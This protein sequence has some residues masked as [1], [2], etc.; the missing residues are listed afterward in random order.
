MDWCIMRFHYAG[1]FATEGDTLT[2]EG[3]LV[4]DLRVDPDRLSW[5][6]L[7]GVLRR[8]GYR[9]IKAIYY[10][11][12][13]ASLA[14]GIRIL[15]NDASVNSMV[16]EMMLEGTIDVYVEH[17]VEEPEVALH[18]IEGPP[19]NDGENGNEGDENNVG[20]AEFVDIE[21]EVEGAEQAAYHGQVAGED[22]SEVDNGDSGMDSDSVASSYRDSSDFGDLESDL[23]E[24]VDEATRRDRRYPLYNEDV[25]V[26][27]ITEGMIFMNAAQFKRADIYGVDVYMSMVRRAKKKIL[28]SYVLNIEEE[29]GQ[30]W[31]QSNVSYR[32]AMVEDENGDSWNWFLELVQADLDHMGNGAGWTIMSDQHKAIEKAIKDITPEAEHREFEENLEKLKAISPD[33]GTDIE[34]YALVQQ[35]CRAFQKEESMLELIDNNLCEALNKTLLEA[36]R[37]SALDISQ[38][39]RVFHNG[40]RGYEIEHGENRY[41]VRL[42][43]KTCSCRRY[44]LSG[45]PC[46]HAICAIRDVRVDI[47]EYTSS[48]LW[49][50]TYLKAYGKSLQ[51]VPGKKVWPITND[52]P[53]RPPEFRQKP[54]KPQLARKKGPNEPKKTKGPKKA[55]GGVSRKGMIMTCTH[56]HKQNHNKR[57]CPYKGREIPTATDQEM[58][59]STQ[60]G[61]QHS[62]LNTST[63][64]ASTSNQATSNQAT[65]TQAASNQA[66]SNWKKRARASATSVGNASAS[67]SITAAGINAT[68]NANTR[69]QSGPATAAAQCSTVFSAPST[70]TGTAPGNTP[71]TNTV[72]ASSKSK[73]KRKKG[74]NTRQVSGRRGVGFS[75]VGGAGNVKTTGGGRSSPQSRAKAVGK[76][77]IT[78]S[79]LQKEAQ[80]K[81]KK[82]FGRSGSYTN[83]FTE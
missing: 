76:K 1:Y 10:R 79:T 26:P 20:G 2:Y 81:F 25:V 40:Q 63:A 15:D 67:L 49:K 9:N 33:A 65:S 61:Q 14:N 47:E 74:P 68:T 52:E 73:T 7:S 39:C 80:A 23:E 17:G 55:S 43:E 46:A 29:F 13:Y 18:L 22:A 56:C 82:K 45:I 75:V 16:S 70:N 4:D 28:E 54:G 78:Y 44:N 57:A 71:G 53:V 48:W 66:A 36:R 5:Y 77:L 83:Q 42:D 11:I 19:A 69:T 37:M 72:S 6:E 3:G 34:K 8:G 32:L 64:A 35:W 58:G 21:V 50:E 38:H 62:Q 24:I 51:P 31:K 60:T 59:Q 27:H 12:Q 30:R 41:L